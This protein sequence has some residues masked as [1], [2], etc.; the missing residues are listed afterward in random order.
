[1]ALPGEADLAR[2]IGVDVDP[3]A[4][5]AARKSLRG[6]LGRAHAARLQALH[7]RMA[8]SGPFTPDAASAGRR[9]LRN[10]ALAMIVA[11]NAIDGA[12]RAHASSPTPTT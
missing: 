2:E 6:K 1:M 11:G 7:D 4:I 8:D 5:R 12:Q 9:A 10:G 3:D